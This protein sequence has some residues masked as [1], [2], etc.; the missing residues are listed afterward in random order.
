MKQDPSLQTRLSDTRGS[1]AGIGFFRLW[2]RIFGY[3]HCK[4]MVWFVT[5]FYMLFDSGARK[6]VNPYIRHRFPPAGMLGRCR[7][8]WCLFAHQGL[9]LLRQELFAQLGIQYENVYDSPEARRVADS[10]KSG[11]L[12]Y[13][14]FGPWQMMMRGR[15]TSRNT[16]NFLA[17]DDRNVTID[18]MKSFSGEFPAGKVVPVHAGPGSLFALEQALE[19]NE[20]IAVM[21]DRNFEEAPLQVDFL[22]EKADFPVAAF[23][24]AARRKCPVVCLFARPDDKGS[25][26]LEFCEAMEVE[27]KGRSREQLRPYL[28]R[29]VRHL[30]ELCMKYPYDCF[31]MTDPWRR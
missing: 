12:L 3:A 16:V 28:E 9:C 6:R 18:K 20:L 11:V 14:H 15:A 19:R 4:G 30:E 13:S 10:E 5:F 27:M 1:R 26:V 2:Y 22:G 24:L 25:Y 21:G 7:H 17:Q 29:Y 8:R 31:T 23:Y